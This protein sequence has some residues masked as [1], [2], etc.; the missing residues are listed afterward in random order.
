M[1]DCLKLKV[2]AGIALCVC[3]SQQAA[4]DG[5]F[6]QADLGGQTQGLVAASSTGAISYGFNAVKYEGG[7]AGA[8]SV[9]HAW[10]L[11][12]IATIKAGPTIGFEREDGQGTDIAGGAKASIERY[13]P[14]SFGATYVLADFSTVNDSWFLLTQATFQAPGVSVELSRGGS[15]FYHETT[16]ALQKN[17]SDSPFKLRLGYKVSSEELFAGIAVN[18]F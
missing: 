9:T 14:S 13:S 4:A 1:V 11:G 5:Y 18:T 6:L 15:N 3:L 10:P 12:D 2:V 17:L 8:I 16:V 7:R